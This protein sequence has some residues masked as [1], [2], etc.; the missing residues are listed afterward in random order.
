[1]VSQYRGSHQVLYRLVE[2]AMHTCTELNRTYGI[3]TV[4][5]RTYIGSGGVGA[6]Q[7]QMCV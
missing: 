5:W 2:P 3:C 7:V 1:M 4:G 6:W